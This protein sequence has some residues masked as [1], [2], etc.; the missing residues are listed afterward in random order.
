MEV[1]RG[2]QGPVTPGHSRPSGAVPDPTVLCAWRVWAGGQ[3]A[4]EGTVWDEDPCAQA[5]GAGGWVAGAYLLL[6]EA[7]VCPLGSPSP[8]FPSCC[9]QE[10]TLSFQGCQSQGPGGGRE[11]TRSHLP[12]LL[13][14]CGTAPRVRGLLKLVQTAFSPDFRTTGQTGGEG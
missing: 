11:L 6:S 7:C 10:P 12:D 9:P 13:G 4:Q 8:P 1:M 3:G 5:R 14:G 2:H